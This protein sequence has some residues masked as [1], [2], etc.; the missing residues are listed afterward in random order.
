MVTAWGVSGAWGQGAPAAAPA[1][2]P[3]PPPPEA[4]A[5]VAADGSVLSLSTEQGQSPLNESF[6]WP[7]YSERVRAQRKKA[8]EDTTFAIQLRTMYLDRNKY[9]DT[10]SEGWAAGGSAGL[11]TGY[12]RNLLSLGATGYTSQRIVGEDDKDGTLLLKPGQ[13][14]YSVLGELYGDFKLSD[15]VSIYAGRKAYDTPYINRNDTRMTPNTFEAYTIQGR[16][17]LA[18]KSALK[19]GAGYFDKIKERNSDEFVAMSED[20]G[21]TINHGVFTAG[22]VYDRGVFTIGAIDYYC[23]DIINIAYGEAKC[24]M[25]INETVKLT[26]AA[27]YTDQESTGDDLL[28]GEDFSAEQYGLKADLAVG[29]A[30][31]TVA[32][33]DTGDGDGMQSPWSGYPGYTS[34][35]VEDFNR[36]GESAV[37]LRAAY[38]FKSVEGLSAYGL[39]VNGSDP[40]GA[41]TFERDEYNLN[42]QWKASKGVAKGLSLRTRYA[43]V[44]EEDSDSD[45]LTDFRVICS[46]DMPW[47]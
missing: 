5:E 8:I 33:T 34:V 16:A 31:F 44:T 45:D 12:F 3:V 38:D 37:M 41:D 47:K 18:E 6:D 23:E 26:L 7:T 13:R 36:A 10:E 35:Q 32:Y 43:I 9:D 29:A 22:A 24:N 17:K 21:S 1:A 39:W 14:A 19:Y 2:A 40:D 42:L 15:E 25:P 30:T 20:A 11:K 27:Q 4:A 46:Y 28:N